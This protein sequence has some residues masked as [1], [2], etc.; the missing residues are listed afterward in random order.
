MPVVF[1]KLSLTGVLQPD[2][3]TWH[4]CGDNLF[5]LLRTSVVPSGKR[6]CQTEELHPCVEIQR[7]SRRA[8]EYDG[9]TTTRP[10]LPA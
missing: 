9:A 2:H 5:G 1:V 8:S 10:T 4:C 6:R 3:F 7:A